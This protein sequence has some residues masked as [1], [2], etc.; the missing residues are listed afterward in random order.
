MVIYPSDLRV[1]IMDF[2]PIDH[3]LPSP[4]QL[5][6]RIAEI[7]RASVSP[8]GMFGF[9]VP[10]YLGQ[11]SQPSEWDSDWA[12]LF[13][14]MLDRL[15]QFPSAVQWDDRC[16]AE[17]KRLVTDTVPR[18]LGPLQSD[19]RRLKPCLVHG[20]LSIA[21]MGINMQ[22][23]RPV[24]FSPSGLYAHNE[25]ELGSWCRRTGSLSWAYFREYRNHFPP[26]DPV[27]QWDDRILLYSITFNLLDLVAAPQSSDI[28]HQ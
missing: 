19:E 9:P 16:R 24:I 25:Y 14:R 6:A 3:T 13:G 12:A 27:E 21:N 17:F 28:R 23:G 15:V 18:I 5:C 8:R 22:T 4:A 11:F 1:L 7:H 2:I 20:D 26:A 10:T